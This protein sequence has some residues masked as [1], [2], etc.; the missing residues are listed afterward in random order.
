MPETIANL[1]LPADGN[2]VLP[3]VDTS[4][5]EDR[6]ILRGSWTCYGETFDARCGADGMTPHNYLQWSP[7]EPELIGENRSGH[8]YVYRV[9]PGSLPDGQ[10]LTVRLDVDRL[11]DRYVGQTRSE[12]VAALSGGLSVEVT[13]TALVAPFPWASVLASSLVG[14][15]AVGGFLWVARRRQLLAGIPPELLA[16][17]EKIGEKAAA[18]RRAVGGQA[19][20]LPL[21]ERVDALARAALPLA[22]QATD[23]RN[24]R[25]TVDRPT[26]LRAVSLIEDRLPALAPGTPERR[27]AEATRDEKQKALARL[28]ELERAEALCLLRL[29]KIEAV[30]DSTALTLHSAQARAGNPASEEHLRKSL[31]AE[32]AA[33][34]AVAEQAPELQLMVGRR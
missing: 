13:R 10:S 21:R 4:R 18:A 34:H 3:P 5:F 30:L 12:I 17:V 26:L 8:E 14:S 9:R 23:L 2:V 11:I 15:A 25:A 20:T 24:A 33:V 29:E 31:D 7:V 1:P 32:V 28:D 6:V 27:E 22:R 19:G 16:R